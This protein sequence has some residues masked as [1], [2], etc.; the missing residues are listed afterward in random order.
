M[1]SLLAKNLQALL[2]GE[3]LKDFV[4]KDH[5]SLVSLSRFSTVGNLMGNPTSGSL[6]VEGHLAR[7]FYISLY[8]LH[9]LA[10]HGPL[11]TL[12]IALV[13]RIH[14]V[15]RPRLKLH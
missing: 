15:I 5:G 8:R 1:A 6:F 2:K 7:L 14:R 3:P 11:A 12:L 10:L 9:Q 13:D 4:Y